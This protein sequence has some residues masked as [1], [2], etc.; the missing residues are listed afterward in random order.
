MGLERGTLALGSGAHA[1]TASRLKSIF[2]GSVGNLVEWYDWFVYSAFSIYF[3]KAFF[4]NG[5]LTAQLLGSAAVFAVG[6]LVR[7][8]G[9]WI[10]GLY[11]DRKGRKAALTLSVLVMC[12]GSLLIALTPTYQSIGIAAPIILL[13]A[14]LLQ[15]LSLGG[16]YGASAAYLSEMATPGR[17]GFYSSFQYATMI[18]GQ[19]LALGVLILLQ[20]AFLS[21][22]QIDAWGW[23]VPFVIGAMCAVVA[24]Y[25]RRGMDETQSFTTHQRIQPRKNLLRVLLEHPRSV[26][27]VAGLTLGGTVAFYTYTTYMQKYLVNS[28]GW[29][30]NQ[31]TLLSAATLFLFMLLQPVVGLLS[32]RFGRRPFLIVFGVLGTTLTVPILSALSR[33]HTMG[34]AFLLVMG[35]L[36]IVSCYTSISGVVKAELFPAEIRA[37]GIGLPHAIT[38]SV[39]GGTAEGVA[40]WFKKA[41]HESWYYGYVTLCIAI[42]LM[43]YV[44]MPETRT[45]STMDQD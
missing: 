32:D 14:R 44:T 45:Q 43:V 17:R 40:L 35:A 42:S 33:T 15:G 11:A 3:A 29:S 28:V 31:A 5:D 25:M 18:L 23:R 6:F 20:R 38:V 39:F 7:P 1:R 12:L 41:G 21:G 36:V 24:L 30:A 27:T 8:L 13:F 4:P 22:P 9:G 26:F 19:L 34:A 2:G 10:L 37:L 16:E